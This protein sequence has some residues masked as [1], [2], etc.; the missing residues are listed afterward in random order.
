M[1]NT[2][3]GKTFLFS[4]IMVFTIASSSLSAQTI[5]QSEAAPLGQEVQDDNVEL[6]RAINQ[7]FQFKL[8]NE[9][10]IVP[11]PNVQNPDEGPNKLSL[12]SV[13]SGYGENRS[14]GSEQKPLQVME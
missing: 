14:I 6:L 4:F 12:N 13:K 5:E 8:K 2:G 7:Q 3:A 10:N 9:V 11:K 1:G